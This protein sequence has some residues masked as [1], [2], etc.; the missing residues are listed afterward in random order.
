[1][2]T[3]RE[4]APIIGTLVAALPGVPHGAL[5]YRL[6][7]LPSCVGCHFL[8]A[9]SDILWWEYHVRGSFCQI[10][11]EPVHL[12][13]FSDASLEGW[14]G[15]DEVTHVGGCGRRLKYLTTSM[16]WNYRQPT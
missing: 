7:M 8:N 9:P 10:C 5:H 2:H 6:K 14:G 4:V 15:T 3:T 12:T 11:W 13:L 1:M 16:P